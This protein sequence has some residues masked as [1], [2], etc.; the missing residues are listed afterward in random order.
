MAAEE[1]TIK[2]SLRHVGRERTYLLHPPANKPEGKLP[3][4]IVLHGGR[5][6]GE[7]TERPSGM[8]AVSD[9]EGFIVAYPDGKASGPSFPCDHDQRPCEPAASS[10]PRRPLRPPLDRSGAVLMP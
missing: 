6:R 2:L 3:L 4:V 7:R 1:G 5:G 8:S 10:I 9:R